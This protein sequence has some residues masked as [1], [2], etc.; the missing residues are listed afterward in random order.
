MLLTLKQGIDL[1]RELPVPLKIVLEGLYSICWTPQF[2][3]LDFQ[4]CG[5]F[6][7]L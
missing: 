6:P 1:Y 5:M 3:L 4:L 2:C 7:V